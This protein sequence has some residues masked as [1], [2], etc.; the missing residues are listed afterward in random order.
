MASLA[1]L[2]V[3]EAHHS[4]A[5]HV[6]WNP[7]GSLLASC[8]GDKLIK[9]WG[10]EGNTWV[11]K[12]ILEGA[13]QR[14][15]RCVAWSPCGTY[16]ASVSFDGTTAIWDRKAGEFECSATLEGHENEVKSVS[17]A[18]GG[19]LLATCSRDKSVWIWEVDQDQ[20]YECASVLSS[21]TQDVKCVLWHPHQDVLLSTSYDN[22]IK[23]YR[24]DGDDWSCFATLA[25]HD[26]TVWAADLDHTGTRLVSCSDDKTMKIWQEYLPGNEYGVKTE[27]NSPTWKCVCTVS[28]FHD[29]PIYHVKWCHL[30][31]LI[32]TACGDD[33]IRVFEE[34]KSS[35]DAVNEPSFNLLV[36]VTRA[37]T[38]DVNCV[39]WNPTREGLLASCSDDGQVKVWQFTDES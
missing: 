7:Q 30:S 17:W 26:S 11:C 18:C 12:T 24:E 37:H 31:G 10:E 14:T 28:G 5:W 23:L 34:D 4:R 6:A 15:I 13:H 21:H 8:G 25:S 27:G 1:E 29:R 22:T 38:Q 3:L 39:S 9:I 20:E 19:S 16:L 35:S 32:A 36:K 33:C 2:C